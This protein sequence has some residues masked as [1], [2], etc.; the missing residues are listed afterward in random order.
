MKI[1]VAGPM[2]EKTQVRRTADN[3]KFPHFHEA[4][5]KLEAVGH[6]VYN[7]ATNWAGTREDDLY[8][9]KSPEEWAAFDA[10]EYLDEYKRVMARDVRW[11]LEVDAVALLP[12]WRDSQ[13]ALFEH[14]IACM[15]GKRISNVDEFE[16]EPA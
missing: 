14:S 7:P 13:G 3:H 2:T 11:I 16:A 5:K 12:G 10:D 1:Y 15:L 8:V 9:P 6:I 4:A